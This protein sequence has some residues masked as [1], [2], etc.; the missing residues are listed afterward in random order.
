[1]GTMKAKQL[2]EILLKHPELDVTISRHWGIPTS[3]ADVKNIIIDEHNEI[4]LCMDSANHRFHLELGI[5]RSEYEEMPY[6]RPNISEEDKTKPFILSN[7]LRLF[8]IKERL[9]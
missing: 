2:A 1:M 6:L 4:V 7:Q 8:N 3:S 5:T 9:F